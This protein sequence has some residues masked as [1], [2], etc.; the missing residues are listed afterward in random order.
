MRLLHC[1]PLAALVAFQLAAQVGEPPTL[2]PSPM[3]FANSYGTWITG[4]A[5]QVQFSRVGGT[6]CQTLSADLGG[7]PAGF[8]WAPAGSA[9][10]AVS[11]TFNSTGKFKFSLAVQCANGNAG[12]SYTVAVNLPMT[13]MEGPYL[14]TG[15]VGAIY[16]TFLRRNGVKPYALTVTS[17]ALPPGLQWDADS[18]VLVGTPTTAGTYDF[19]VGITDRMGTSGQASYTLVV[20]SPGGFYTTTNRLD[21]QAMVGGA[22]D[23][24]SLG[25]FTSDLT[26]V[27]YSVASDAAWLTAT[28]GTGK[29]PDELTVR[30]NPSGLAKGTY[31]GQLRLT[32]DKG[33]SPVTV[34]VAVQIKD[35][36]P[37]LAAAPDRAQVELLPET[38]AARQFQLDFQAWNAG[39]GK[40][41]AKAWAWGEVGGRAWLSVSPAEFSATPGQT[42]VLTVNVN[43][44]GLPVGSYRGSIE[45]A[46]ST[47]AAGAKSIP[48]LLVVPPVQHFP[49]LTL[50]NSSWNTGPDWYGLDDIF[51]YDNSSIFVSNA[52]TASSFNFAAAL[53]GFGA[54]GYV[55]PT[56]GSVGSWPS[57]A[58]LNFRFNNGRLGPGQHEG[59]LTVTAPGAKNSPSYAKVKLDI[60]STS[61]IT[62]SATVTDVEAENPILVNPAGSTKPLLAQIVIT[63]SS[64]VPVSYRVAAD[65]ESA[66]TL[67][68]PAGAV[69]KAN[70]VTVTATVDP[71]KLTLDERAMQLSVAACSTLGGCTRYGVPAYVITP[72]GGSPAAGRQAGSDRAAEAAACTASR[73]VLGVAVPPGN[74]QRVADEPVKLRAVVYD[75]CGLPVSNATV[76]ASFSNG[77]GSVTL[78]VSDAAKGVY[79]TAWI[80]GAVAPNMA[81]TLRAARSGLA[82]GTRKIFGTVTEDSGAPVI[83]NGGIVNAIRSVAGDP[84]SPGGIVAIYGR[85]LAART[86][87][88][89]AVPLPRTLGGA[90]VLIGGVEAPFFYASPGQLNV[91]VPIELAPDASYSVVVLNGERISTPKPL[92]LVK[93][94]PGVVAFADGRII[95]QHADYSLI[96]PTSPAR[97]GETIILYLVGMGPTTPKVAT[98]VGTPYPPLTYVDV[99]PVVTIGGLAT[100][101]EW[102]GLV[103]GAVG[104]YQV[105]CTVPATAP[106]GELTLIL[107][108]DGVAS[109]Q[110]TIAVTTAR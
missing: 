10:G 93:L 108:Q 5:Y 47:T 94:D 26:V 101:V 79:E 39:T 21:F 71:N 86:E 43:A 65:P 58:E 62:G 56:G 55:T 63:N 16:A 15:T 2:T 54:N 36:A 6:N 81:I 90:K 31:Q 50:S 73:L 57:A 27:N 103:S 8:T 38:G 98:G 75:D 52:D 110:V 48:V 33:K 53:S 105:I 61:Q 3:D 92:Q 24:M 20:G 4:K 89:A 59:L 34:T 17:G 88:A 107:A 104:L 91:Q 51:D 42:Q 11:G 84:V 69:S 13:M 1:V 70:P 49:I 28:P 37:L 29:T 87:Q 40:L 66:V 82:V 74:F 78:P 68:T 76:T 100:K 45:I 83:T 9:G 46:A 22:A 60:R 18:G 19:R 99:Q 96:T 25:V 23:S 30:M 109:N 106:A 12:L 7:L 77:D 67:D 85:N 102:A 64:N 80:P 35:P 32:P 72:A 97:A 44:Q 95:G 41:T 14:A